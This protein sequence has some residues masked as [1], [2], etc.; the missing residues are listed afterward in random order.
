MAK[1]TPRPTPD[2]LDPQLTA[3]LE[4][5]LA[6]G[7]L[8]ELLAILLSRLALA[9]RSAYLDATP[10]DKANGYYSRSLEAGSL[11]LSLK[12][13]RTRS[14]AFRPAVLPPPYQRAFP[15]HKRELLL[16]L[17]ANSRSLEAAKDTLRHL[18]LS[19]PD[20]ELDRIVAEL[21]QELDLL[22]TRPVPVDLLALYYDAK[23]VEIREKDRLRTF[24]IYTAVGVLTNGL[25][26]VLAC[27][28]LPGRESLE[29]W[30]QVLKG[31]LERGLRRVLIAIHDD[32]PGLLALSK[33]LFPNADIQLCIVH[34][35]RNVGRHLPK[36]DARSFLRRLK[37]IK[38][39]Y[40]PETAAA[41]FEDL[42]HHFQAQAPTF[43]RSIRSKR[44]H[45]LAF[46]HYPDPVRKTFSTTNAV[47]AINGQLEISRLNSGGYFQ[48]QP[49]AKAK[50]AIAI[51]RLESKR[52]RR[53]AANLASA[54]T[55]LNLM[56]QARFETDATP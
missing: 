12:V 19:V 17:V 43:I 51:T 54:L 53:P 49:L 7:T 37:A 35:E 8:N 47:E 14:G 34:M 30:K 11:P 27:C 29:G 40:D 13:P 48:S 9:E 10:E 5:K 2:Q 3:L 18:G 42:C 56:F 25:K 21:T 55:D 28:L 20:S 31:L 6:A 24:T 50:L 36:Q 22:N 26:R 33:S 39:S 15:E 4:G 45:Y 52:W 32:F 16:G 23:Y 41:Q 1:D 44:E 38:A 46:L